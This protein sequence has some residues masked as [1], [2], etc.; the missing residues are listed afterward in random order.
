MKVRLWRGMPVRVWTGVPKQNTRILPPGE[1]TVMG[2]GKES[3]KMLVMSIF[4]LPVTERNEI[5]L[6]CSNISIDT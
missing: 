1:K 3:F 6:N 4:L 2:L 5:E